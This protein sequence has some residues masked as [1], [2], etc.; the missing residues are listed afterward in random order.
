MVKNTIERF[1]KE[2]LLSKKPTEGLKIF[3]PKTPTFYITPKIHKESNPRRPVINSIDPHTSEISRFVDHHLQ[4]AVNEIS[5][6]I[7]YK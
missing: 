4:P 6:Y 1:R 3:D 5:S 2:N 7:R